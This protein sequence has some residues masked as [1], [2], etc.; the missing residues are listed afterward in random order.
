[1]Y[2]ADP[3]RTGQVSSGP[4]TLQ[5]TVSGPG[6]LQVSPDQ[7]TYQRYSTVTIAVQAAQN[8]QFLGWEGYLPAHPENNPIT[9]FLDQ[10]KQVHAVFGEALKL[11]VEIQDGSLLITHN[12]SPYREWMLE[13]SSDLHDWTPV[14]HLTGRAPLIQ[15][16]SAGIHFFRLRSLN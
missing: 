6:Q 8:S 4:V 3:Q 1:M 9:V 15:S 11:S 13:T 12:G 16:A 14:T 10:S 2:R 7:T 5:A